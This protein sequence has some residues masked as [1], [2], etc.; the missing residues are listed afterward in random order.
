MKDMW[1]KTAYVGVTFVH[2]LR[3]SSS[4]WMNRYEIVS[5][6]EEAETIKAR[7]I[8]PKNSLT[9]KV[10]D[11]STYR[12]MTVEERAKVQSKTVTITTFSNRSTI[13]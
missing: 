8:N 4:I 13:L 1:G 5:I 7:Q 9:Y 2:P 10:W 3:Q 11:G 6:D 12:D